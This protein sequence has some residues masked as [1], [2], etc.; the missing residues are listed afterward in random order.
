MGLHGEFA[1]R[2]TQPRRISLARAAFTGLTELIDP[3]EEIGGNGGA[4][5]LW[6]SL[7]LS[8]M[9]VGGVGPF[10]GRGWTPQG[11]AATLGPPIALPE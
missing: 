1:K 4:R 6:N 2:E 5:R 7:P 10:C 11:F 3:A 9:G 8:T